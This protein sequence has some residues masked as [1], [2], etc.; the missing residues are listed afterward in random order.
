MFMITNGTDEDFEARFDGRDYLFPKGQPVY[1]DDDVAAHIF[2]VGNSDKSA[3][4]ARHG[5]SKPG[6]TIADGMKILNSFTFAHMAPVYDA[7]LAL[8][9]HGP[10]P[11][12]QDAAGTEGGTDG[13]TDAPAAVAARRDPTR[14]Q[15]QPPAA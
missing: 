12:G 11:V 6:Q 14:N 2:A 4:L 5:W 13:S 8:I 9:D 15:R 1:C 3:V 10:A 7:P